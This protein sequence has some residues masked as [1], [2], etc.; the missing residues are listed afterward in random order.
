MGIFSDF[1]VANDND[2]PSIG[3]SVCPAEQWSCLAGWKGIET[4]K[5][6]TL[7]FCITDESN[8][9]EKVAAL[10]SEFEFAG[11]NQ[12][13]GPWVFKFPV[14]VLSA[15]A[16]LSPDSFGSVAQKWCVTEE[17]AGWS[18]SDAYTFISQL[19]PLANSAIASNQAMYLW[20][21]L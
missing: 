15:I 21:S 10:S 3:E 5:L 4:M 2:G 6:S 13:E 16:S 12:D 9:F 8:A 7:Y 14:K 19:Q 17:M 18:L 11:G 20:L 1:V